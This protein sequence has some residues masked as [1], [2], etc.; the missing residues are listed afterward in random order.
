MFYLQLCQ[1]AIYSSQKIMELEVGLPQ[2]SIDC[3]S[4][5]R[6]EQVMDNSLLLKIRHCFFLPKYFYFPISPGKHL[7]VLVPGWQSD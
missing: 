7:V 3:E 1:S 2:R 5:D 4:C 6:I